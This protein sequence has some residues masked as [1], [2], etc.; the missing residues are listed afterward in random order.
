M[1]SEGERFNVDHVL[2]NICIFILLYWLIS[3]CQDWTMFTLYDVWS[4]GVMMECEDES[5]SALAPP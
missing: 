3:S 1:P 5:Q 2:N 4:P